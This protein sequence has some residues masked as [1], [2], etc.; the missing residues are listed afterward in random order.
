MCEEVMKGECSLYRTVQDNL[1][2]QGEAI[3]GG[4]FS[5]TEPLM[6]LLNFTEPPDRGRYSSL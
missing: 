3:I 2:S 6:V 1:Y 4:V 5:L